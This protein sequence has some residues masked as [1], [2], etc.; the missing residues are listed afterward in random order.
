M[1]LILEKLKYTKY[2][3]STTA[4]YT[5]YHSSTTANYLNVWRKFNEF[6]FK[7]DAKPKHWEHRASLFGAF[8]VDRGFQSS[9]LKSYISAIKAILVDDG[10]KGNDD[11]VLLHTLTKSCRI[12]NDCI[13]TKLPIQ[14]SLL[15]LILFE[16]QKRWVDQTFLRILYQAW[17]LIAYYSL[18]RIGKLA[19]SKH[20]IKAANVHIATNK[21]KLLFILYT[22]KTHNLGNRP[23]KIKITANN[24]TRDEAI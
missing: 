4:N 20:C 21:N 19:D 13:S 5:K 14:K 15:E 9:T 23:Q 12:Q 16:I 3:S 11:M 6:V 2:H 18:F 8:L 7:L 10:Y 1:H 17:L 22:S 24:Y